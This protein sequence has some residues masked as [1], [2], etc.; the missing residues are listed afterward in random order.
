MRSLENGFQLEDL[1]H[2]E[3]P[4]VFDLRW[5]PCNPCSTPNAE[6]DP[7]AEARTPRQ[8]LR[9]TG[10]A[11]EM[12]ALALAD[13]SLQLVGIRRDAITSLAT[14]PN[15]ACGGMNLSCDWSHFQ[16]PDVYSSSSNGM[17]SQC[18]VAEGGMVKVQEWQAHDMET[19]MVACDRHQVIHFG[20][21]LLIPHVV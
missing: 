9:G 19:W 10:E 21:F 15:A 7:V 11:G 14:E 3:C 8:H 17:I 1:C 5:C 16:G 12:A 18:R 6:P 2:Y 13:G 4:G 20:V